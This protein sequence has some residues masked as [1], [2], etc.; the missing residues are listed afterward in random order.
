MSFMCVFPMEGLFPTLDYFFLFVFEL[1]KFHQ[2]WFPQETRNSYIPFLFPGNILPTPFLFFL[3]CS[4]IS[5]TKLSFSFLYY[6]LSPGTATNLPTAHGKG[7]PVHGA[8][9]LCAALLSTEAYSDVK[10][11]ERSTGAVIIQKYSVLEPNLHGKKNAQRLPI[12]YI[13]ISY[14]LMSIYK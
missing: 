12:L 11:T 6:L 5:E 9:K 2:S 10:F 7:P 3:S 4:I 14:A 1:K 13:H 8:L